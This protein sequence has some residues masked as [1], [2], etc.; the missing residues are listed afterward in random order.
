MG[1]AVAHTLPSFPQT[2][3]QPPQR[4]RGNYR[5]RSYGH[6]SQSR[7]PNYSAPQTYYPPAA[8]IAA[9]M[10]VAAAP[11]PIY[12]AAPPPLQV[13]PFAL[14]KLVP[15]APYE[16]TPDDH[17]SPEPSIPVNYIMPSF[18]DAKDHI[19]KYP[20]EKDESEQKNE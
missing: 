16:D 11:A 7:D 10:V 17:P 12:Y 8:P 18:T 19:E 3:N 9:P 4:G 13:Q 5:G 15:S 20:G 6:R 1:V 2:N 14:E